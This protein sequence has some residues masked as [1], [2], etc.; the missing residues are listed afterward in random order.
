MIKTGYDV[1]ED[2]KH[3][4]FQIRSK[5]EIILAEFNSDDEREIFKEI[6]QFL[7]DGNNFESLSAL[8]MHFE[9][10][11]SKDKILSVFNELKAFNLIDE[12]KVKEV[13][14]DNLKAQMKF[15]DT[16]SH[17][18]YALN[19]THAQT[20]IKNTR[21]TILG[22]SMFSQLLYRKA[23][24]SGFENLFNDKLI[25]PKD[26]SQIKELVVSSDFLIVD[27]ED[28]SPSFL[29]EFNRVAYENNRPW[30]LSRGIE[31]T[32]GSVGPLFA[33][34]DTGCYQC[35]ISRLKSN[36]EF[37]PYFEE[38]EKYL[39]LKKKSAIS[40]GGLTA[41]Y[42]VLAS[43]ALLESIKFVTGWAV[44]VIYKA[45]IVIDV[46]DYDFKIHPFL[47]SPVCPVCFPK[48]DFKLSPWLEP[49][50]VK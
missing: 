10:R 1:F 40:S 43:L 34:K 21:L 7:E 35:L 25:T 13:Y 33:G 2:E 14:A 26:D 3:N 9:S 22:N 45:F 23:C 46:Y 48:I 17:A 47:K 5:S 27:A 6:A 4:V 24:E 28:W 29:E 37:L 38:Y 15:W 36:M 31:G 41:T 39:K 20:K 50:Y 32:R 44:P 19:G 12:E 30:I 42:D 18:K 8:E 11:Y 49:L 16:A